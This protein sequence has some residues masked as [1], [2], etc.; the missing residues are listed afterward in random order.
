MYTSPPPQFFWRFILFNHSIMFSM[1]SKKTNPNPKKTRWNERGW[2][3][4]PEV[5]Q[6]PPFVWRPCLRLPPVQIRPFGSWLGW[7]R[8]MKQG[9]LIVSLIGGNQWLFNKPLI[10]L[11]F[12]GGVGW[13]A[14]IPTN[15][16]LLEKIKSPHFWEMIQFGEHIFQMGWNHHLG[17]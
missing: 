8:G 12:G 17:F 5:A 3:L 2:K 4:T 15:W 14:K 16:P 1:D 11:W 9:G 7:E 10:R 6:N 13:L